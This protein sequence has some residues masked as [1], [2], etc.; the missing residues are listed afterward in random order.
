MDEEGWDIRARAT[1]SQTVSV[2]VRQHSFR[3]GAPISFDIEYGELSALEYVLGAVAADVIAS[4]Q[5]LAH[6]QRLD[7]EQVEALVH[8]EL[9]NPLMHL[10]VVGEA[11]HPGLSV[12]KVK[13]YVSSLD[14]EE[15]VHKVWSEALKRS[16]LATTFMDAGTLEISLEVVL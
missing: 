10:G 7:V 5:K 13:C 15:Q 2:Y 3:V 11:G 4:F 8:G 6:R 9:D 16:P 14:D 1:D 12:L